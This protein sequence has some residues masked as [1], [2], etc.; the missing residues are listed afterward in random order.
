MYL[1]TD[2]KVALREAVCRP[3][4]RLS[5]WELLE[6]NRRDRALVKQARQEKKRSPIPTIDL[7]AREVE[8]KAL[9]VGLGVGNVTGSR[10]RKE[11]QSPAFT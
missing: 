6:S 1:F 3:S 2:S 7:P 10:Q 4:E 8:Y 11:W 5:P 9:R